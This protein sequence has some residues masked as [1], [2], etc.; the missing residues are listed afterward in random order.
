MLSKRYQR[1]KCYLNH[2]SK[3]KRSFDE[4]IEIVHTL[5]AFE[6]FDALAGSRHSP[7]E[8][9]PIVQ[10]LIFEVLALDRS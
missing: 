1:L 7:E 8:V 2:G 4:I 3:T 5:T 9:V 10:K 6:T